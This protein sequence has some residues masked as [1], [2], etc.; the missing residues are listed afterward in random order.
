MVATEYGEDTQNLAL[1]D[2]RLTGKGHDSFDARPLWSG[3][4]RVRGEIFRDEYWRSG[5]ADVAHL[6]DV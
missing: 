5:P 3:D 6:P 2:Q 1:E 4:R